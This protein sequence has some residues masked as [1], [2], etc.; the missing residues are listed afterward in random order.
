MNNETTATLKREYEKRATL[1]EPFLQRARDCA[2]LTIPSLIP[3]PGAG[4]HTIYR[5]PF[6]SVGARGVNSLANKLLL[7]TLPPNSPFFR[8]L[9]SPR[10]LNLLK[11]ENPQLVS[12]IELALADV[13][14]QVMRHIETSPLRATLFEV[15]RHLIVGGNALLII[16]GGDIRMLPLSHYVVVRDGAGNLTRIITMETLSPEALPEIVDH[17]A[18]GI[19]P[20]RSDK[21]VEL[22][23]DIF[24]HGDRWYIEQEING[25]TIDQEGWSWSKEDMPYIPLRWNKVD[26]EDYGR[27]YVEDLLGDLISCEGLSQSIV[28][29]AALVSAVKFLV[30]PNGITDVGDLES[31]ANGAYVP[32]NPEDVQALRVDK[33]I[34]LTVASRELQEL[35][36]DLREAFLMAGTAV[37]DAERVT[38]EEVRLLAQE[39]EAN[40]GGIYSLLS[41]ELQLPLVR[42]LIKQMQKRGEIPELP[43]GTVDPVVITG[44]DAIGRGQDLQR[45][46]V[47]VAGMQEFLGPQVVAQVLNVPEY[48]RRRGAALGLNIDGL[49]RTEQEFASQQQQQFQQQ[50]IER[51]A[52]QAVSAAER[53]ISNATNE[54]PTETRA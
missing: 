45:L 39:L 29:G 51:A 54:N 49:V 20:D 11:A 18:Y 47:F 32:G 33:S 50:L 46:D 26:G 8:L 4:R 41:Q 35:K 34:D 17:E 15:M 16:D 7:A 30:N 14:Q 12:E 27:G 2:K 52:P 13:E 38:A 3:P 31:A 21:D 6:Q 5:D 53:I 28:E 37:R 43:K 24:L 1:R 10:E 22:Y 44:L 23:T 36:R 19:N 9:P 40:L 48:L 42:T 25:K